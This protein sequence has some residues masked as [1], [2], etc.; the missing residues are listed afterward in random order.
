MRHDKLAE[1]G[2][3]TT[4]EDDPVIPHQARAEQSQTPSQQ[5]TPDMFPE[6]RK[7]AE[8]FEEFLEPEEQEEQI[9]VQDEFE[10]KAR[11][12]GW[13]P[14]N[15]WHGNPDD[16]T[17]AKRFVQTGEMIQ[18]NRALHQ[19]VQY[20]EN[21]FNQ[22]INNMRMLHEAQLQANLD[23]LKARRD[24]AVENA[25]TETYQNINK[26]IEALEQTNAQ[27]QVPT[28]P[29]PES[30]WPPSPTRTAMRTRSSWFSIPTSPSNCWASVAR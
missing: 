11:Q 20:M 3:D 30:T 18:A 15:E 24:A 2:N 28:P 7:I 1:W 22:R 13:V 10:V 16:W 4:N 25:D 12:M 14:R 8:A 26:Q 9:P 21:D 5:Q 17:P 27:F 19:K 6:D 23:Q 29:M